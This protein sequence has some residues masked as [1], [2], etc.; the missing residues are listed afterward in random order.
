M[1]R[2]VTYERKRAKERSYEG[3]IKNEYRISKPVKSTIRR[4]LKEKEE[5]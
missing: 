2:E 4:G 5:K 1:L 3:E